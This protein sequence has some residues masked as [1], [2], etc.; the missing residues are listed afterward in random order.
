MSLR[1]R[2]ASLVVFLLCFLSLN[3]LIV[4]AFSKSELLFPYGAVVSD[5]RL[6]NDTDDF[7]SIEVQLTTP[8]VFYD[9]TYNSIYVNE[10]GLVSFLTEIANFFSIP[11]PLDYPTIAPLYSDVDIRARGAVWYR[12]T[13]DSVDIKRASV[14]IQKHFTSGRGFEAKDLFIVTW[15]DA[16]FYD[17]GNDKGNTFQLVIA[18]DN[19]ESFTLF[20][21]PDKGIQWIQGIGKNPNLPDARAQTGF[22]S[23]DGRFYV[24]KGSGSDQVSNLNKLSNIGVPGLWMFRVGRLG[25]TGEVESPDLATGDTTL[26]QPQGAETCAVGSALCHSKAICVDYNPG[27][28]CQCS[29]GFVG[30]G[31]NCLTEGIPQRINGKVSGRINGVSFQE[32]DLHSYVVTSD[33]RAY[34]AVSKMND[35]IGF[36]LQPLSMLGGVVGWLFARSTSTSAPNGYQLTGGKFNFTTTMDFP[37]SGHRVVIEQRFHGVDV[38]N[39]LRMSIHV[40]GT[41]PSIP[42]GSKIEISDYEEEHHKTGLGEFRSASRRAFRIEGSSLDIP[43]SVDHVIHF[44]ECPFAS[45]DNTTVLKLKVARNFVTY[46][47]RE[48]IVRFAMTTKIS[49]LQETEDPCLK[50]QASCVPNSV[51]IAEKDTFRCVC[52]KGY[53]YYYEEGEAESSCID[54]NECNIG[55]DRCDENALCFNEPGGYQCRCK[56]GYNGDGFNCQKETPCSRVRCSANSM[57]VENE[58]GHPECRCIAGFQEIE[59][60]CQPISSRNMTT[61]CQREDKCDINAQCIY[62]SQADRHVCQ[63][64]SGFRG[65]GLTCIRSSES[66]EQAANCSPYATCT[67]D[68]VLNSYQCVCLPGFEGDGYECVR[69]TCILGVCWCPD[70]YL[71]VND[72]CERSVVS[73]EAPVSC[74]EV[75]ICHSNAHC[76]LSAANSTSPEEQYTCQCNEGYVGDGFQCA[77]EIGLPIV[78]TETPSG[79]DVSGCGPDATCVYDD[80]A[81]KS[82]CV[83]NDGYRGDGLFCTPIDGCSALSDC[84]INAQCL[85]S[86]RDQRFQC[87][88]NQG[89]FGDGKSC[90]PAEQI[91]EEEVEEPGCNEVNNCHVNAACVADESSGRY[92]CICRSGFNGNGFHC[93]PSVIGCNV[94]NN[95]HRDAQCLYD[96]ESIGYRC[97]CK[98]GF[99]GSGITCRP[100]ESCVDNESICHVNALCAW[101]TE[102]YYGCRCRE[103]FRG[104]GY[105]CQVIPKHDGK[106]LL[107]SH[108]MSILRVPIQPSPSKPGRP[109]FVQIFQAAVG[110]DIDCHEGRVY[111]SDVNGRIITSAA[112]NGSNSKVFLN[113]D[114]GSPEGI[115]I[116]WAS[117]NMYWTDS[118]RD[119]VEV[120]NLDSKV[121]RVLFNT[122]LINPRGIAVHPSRGLLFWSDWD[123]ANPKIERAN[124]DGTDRRSDFITTSLQLP[125]SL[126]IDFENE[127]ICWADAGVRRIECANLEGGNRKVIRSDVKYPFGLTHYGQ[128]LFWTDWEE[129]TI[130]SASKDEND[131]DNISL[132]VPLGGQGKLYGIVAVPETC[133]RVQS[134]CQVASGGCNAEQICLPNGTNGRT[135]L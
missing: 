69:P 104:D 40:F 101:N 25:Q 68:E 57:C 3:T 17:Q 112:Y 126:T 29:S 58:Q 8:V 77:M 13:R 52:S 33:G 94:I 16:G 6:D 83:C 114:I 19:Q 90:Y 63:C 20:A 39:Y 103:G 128:R 60:Q 115:A 133:P 53:E 2:S 113:S 1:R 107:I 84:D 117:R 82:V 9:Q 79:C 99:T 106:F 10:N 98:E 131:T 30:N 110:I 93:E 135:C 81:L 80:E 48:L 35:S 121:R 91:A 43:F 74:N 5:R 51:C 14:L 54:V 86:N 27:F 102:G 124:A 42:H 56:A 24:L 11:F 116:D 34:T 130:K 87:E 123:R 78:S 88:C 41:V 76:V 62:N 31:R 46:D 97:K 72:K 67:Y 85:F 21:Y 64:L 122:N 50:G 96:P 105:Q 70:G 75:N 7:N 32:E 108:G 120:A 73:G 95:C 66:C 61:D 26:Q 119:T 125:N 118:M 100:L 134:T 22:V 15:D 127:E 37:Q 45:L 36:D 71:Y 47:A 129:K 28:C 23:G 89:Y 44:E 92:V 4:S 109:I 111:W 65:D 59:N 49:P 132:Q 12:E 55:T 18:S 38:F